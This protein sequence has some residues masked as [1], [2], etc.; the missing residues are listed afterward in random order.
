VQAVAHKVVDYI[1]REELLSPGDRLGV[2]V[3]GGIDSVALLRLLLEL[4]TELGI[5]LSVVHLNHKL[6]G[7]ESDRDEDFVS[8]LARAHNL[9]LRSTSIDVGK[10][11]AE[12]RVSIETAARRARYDYFTELLCADSQQAVHLD[13]IATGHTL[14]DQAETVLMR[15]IRGTGVRGLAAIRPRL[16]IEDVDGERTAE[17][18]RPLLEVRRA[19]LEGYLKDLGQCWREDATN[20]DPK[21]TRNRVRGV[22]VPLLEQEF[23]PAIAE[24]LRD[25]A[26]IS[27]GEEDY[28]HNE[29]AGWMGTRIH[30]I[31]AEWASAISSKESELVQLLP[32]NSQAGASTGAL[33]EELN[34]PAMFDVDFTV[35]LFWLLGEPLAVQRR[36]VKAVGEHANIPLEFQH[37]ESVLRLARDEAANEKRLALPLGWQVVRRPESLLFLSPDPRQED[38]VQGDYEHQLPLPGRAIVPEAGI[39]VEALTGRSE[40]S[41]GEELLDRAQLSS[42]LTIRNWR[43][44]DRFWPAHTK[45]PKKVKELLQDL[46]L[47]QPKRRSWPVIVS[48]DE[49][50]W[51]YGFSAP[52]RLRPKD[53]NSEVVAIRVTPMEGVNELEM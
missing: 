21:F 34:E 7:S 11:A 26:E 14:D 13:K 30:A 9:N 28:W 10:Y 41:H 35:D 1:R 52:A 51:L 16:E 36:V 6:R 44:G 27:Y 2:A 39:V 17:I 22:L 18:V 42:K 8:N 33:A 32:V 19:E 48:G 47:P 24:T 20:Q 31:E 25:L 29:V 40:L 15:I 38:R 43:P 5:V 46:H 53:A 49:I 12:H 4:R 50:V 3:S 37:V 23:N 45:A